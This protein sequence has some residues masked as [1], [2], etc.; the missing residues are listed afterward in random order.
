[1]IQKRGATGDDDADALNGR[2]HYLATIEGLLVNWATANWA[3]VIC[4]YIFGLH[5][6]YIL[7]R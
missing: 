2:G 3:L 4:I 6:Y 5:I 1:M 7:Y